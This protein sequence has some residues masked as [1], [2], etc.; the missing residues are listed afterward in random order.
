MF[1]RPS[2]LVSCECYHTQAS[3]ISFYSAHGETEAWHHRGLLRPSSPKKLAG[4]P[5]QSASLAAALKEPLVKRHHNDTLA[6]RTSV[7][8]P[9]KG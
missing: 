2:K 3:R 8:L 7:L 9:V 1:A 5:S 4:L 6:A